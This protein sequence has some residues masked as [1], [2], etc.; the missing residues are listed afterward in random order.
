[1]DHPLENLG[2]ERFQQ[3]CQALLVKE[4]PGTNCL[5]VAQPDGGR[6][7]VLY[8]QESS[9]VTYFTAYQVKFSRNPLQG[10]EARKWI[11]DTAEG[12]IQKVKKLIQRGANRYVVLTN[13]AGTAHLDAGSID[14]LQKTLSNKFDIPVVCW[15]RDDINRRLDAGWDL[16]LRYPEILSGQDFFRLLLHT[17]AGQDHERRLNAVKAFLVDQYVED[18]EVKFKQVELQNKLLDLFV[19][20]PF[21]LTISFDAETPATLTQSAPF[22]VRVLSTETPGTFFIDDFY[23]DHPDAGTATLL[24]SSF[25]DQFIPQVVVEGA[26]GQGKSTL[27]Q[28]ICQV[29]RIRILQKPE[30][31]SKLPI[32]DKQ[33]ALRLPIKVDLRDLA[34]WLVGGDPFS[35]SNEIPRSTDQRTLETFLAA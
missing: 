28:Y 9:S 12:E 31:L 14:K 35:G 25:S 34:A 1:M 30:D 22:L 3:L 20:L 13:V 15:W 4:Y 5:P 33:T 16:K 27:A 10:E 7:A 19:D 8:S 6:D 24:L 23:D 29:Q 2:P 26:P 18:V 32:R 17:I 21:R 11:L